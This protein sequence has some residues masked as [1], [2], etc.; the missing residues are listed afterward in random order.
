M[1]LH[2]QLDNDSFA[3]RELFKSFS[4]NQKLDKNR[5]ELITTKFH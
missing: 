5:I 2:H 1:F 4:E 3:I